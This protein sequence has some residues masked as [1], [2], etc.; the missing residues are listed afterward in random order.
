M[1]QV[2]ANLRTSL[3]QY[4]EY[5]SFTQFGSEVDDATRK[6]LDQGE[7]M[8]AV[9][10]QDRFDPLPTWIQASII[11]AVSNG[12]ADDYESEKMNV[13]EKEFISFLKSSKPELCE[14]LQTGNKMSKET[15]N[16]FKCSIS[17]FKQII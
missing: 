10:R 1:K 14:I 12:A 6:T 15:I 11:F 9:L 8:M 5:A 2:A 13:F 7:R 4:R 17:E 3:A 16:S